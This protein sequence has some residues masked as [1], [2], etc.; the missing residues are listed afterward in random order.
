ME[1]HVTWEK[2][3]QL[4]IACSSSSGFAPWITTTFRHVHNIFDR[5]QAWDT[6]EARLK[7]SKLE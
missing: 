3:S 7:K 1:Q 2:W 5:L 6:F 4:K